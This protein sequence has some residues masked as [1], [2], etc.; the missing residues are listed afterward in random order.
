MQISRI[1]LESRFYTELVAFLMQ[2]LS[3]KYIYE[4]EN[5]LL[6]AGEEYRFRTNSNQMHLIVIKKS[7]PDLEIELVCGGGGEG[8]INITLGAE[9]SFIKKAKRLLKEFCD[10]HHTAF[11]ERE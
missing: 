7:P 6:L 8:L 11:R 5:I 3:T 4:A 9:K 1:G 2:E 10:F